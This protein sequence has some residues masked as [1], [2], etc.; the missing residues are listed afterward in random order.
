MNKLKHFIACAA[1]TLITLT[2]FAQEYK[3]PVDKQYH[4]GAGVVFGV[5]GTFAGNSLQWKPEKA[6]LMGLASATVAGVGKELWDEVD[7]QIG[8]YGTG[9][10][11]RDLGAT[12]IGG[13]IG[14]GLTY[15]GLKIFYRYKPAVFVTNVQK[16]LTVG[17][18]FT[19]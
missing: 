19:I 7:Y 3:I 15:A 16:C 4:L 11:F 5:W 12:M 2:C 9:F 1:I 6:A 17:L 13:V 10:D 8:G 18:R 14:V